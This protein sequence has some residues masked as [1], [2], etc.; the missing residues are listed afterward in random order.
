MVNGVNGNSRSSGT[1]VHSPGKES[2]SPS[3]ERWEAK[4]D[5]SVATY[6]TNL[7]A[8]CSH[9]SPNGTHGVHALWSNDK[10]LVSGN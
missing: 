4:V 7:E 2:L 9:C 6:W 10:T 3:G 5:N 1:P 8:R